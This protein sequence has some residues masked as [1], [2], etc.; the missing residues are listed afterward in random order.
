MPALSPALLQ[1]LDSDGDPD[2]AARSIAETL[3]MRQETRAV[4]PAL[5]AVAEHKAGEEGVYAVVSRRFGTLGKPNLSEGEW[6]NWWADYYDTCADLPLASLEAGMRAWVNNPEAQFIPRPGKLREL[7][8]KSPSQTLRR[9]QRAKRALQIADGQA[10]KAPEIAPEGVHV[11][12]PSA[13]R[14]MLAEYQAKFAERKPAPRA[15]MPSTAGKPD[16]GGLTAEMRALLA[17]RENDA[18]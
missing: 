14:K 11:D 18:P 13:V 17:R 1:L 7:A 5:K 12:Q 3:T 10:Q 9:Y 16:E 2:Q 6:A 4:L 15:P 8:E